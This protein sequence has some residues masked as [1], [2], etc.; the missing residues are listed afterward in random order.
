MA[1][2][3]NEPLI[4]ETLA[5]FV[6]SALVDDGVLP[7]GVAMRVCVD[8]EA[9]TTDT[10]D[11]EVDLP[12]RCDR[13]ARPLGPIAHEQSFAAQPLA[14]PAL[15]DGAEP[16]P[17]NV[18]PGPPSSIEARDTPPVIGA[19]TVP[20]PAEPGAPKPGDAPA[21]AGDAPSIPI[22]GAPSPVESMR[23]AP[24]DVP[25]VSGDAPSI[26]T[27]PAPS[28][29][30]AMAR[31]TGGAPAAGGDA[32]SIPTRG[33][34]SP[35]EA[36]P[37][38]PGNAPAA[39]DDAPRVPVHEP[40]AERVP[41]AV[42]D[43]PRVP[44]GVTAGY[45]APLEKVRGTAPPSEPSVE[46]QTFWFAPREADEIAAQSML[47]TEAVAMALPIDVSLSLNE[48]PIVGGMLPPE[49]GISLRGLTLV[50]TPAGMALR[51]E[52]WLRSE[53]LKV[54]LVFLPQ[55]DEFGDDQ[56]AS[57][58]ATPSGIQPVFWVDVN[59]ALGPLDLQRLGVGFHDEKLWLLMD[60]SLKLG[61]VELI[62]IGLG[63][64]IELG[65]LLSGDPTLPS[66][67]VDG[68]GVEYHGASGTTVGGVL[69]RREED[70]YVGA[71]VVETASLSLSALG[72]FEAPPDGEPS[73]FAYGT[74]GKPLGGP[75]FFYVTRLSLGLGVNTSFT[76][77]AIENVHRF[78]LVRNA[79]SAM[80]PAAP[81]LVD[82]VRT[83]DELRGYQRRTPGTLVLGL[84][85]VGTSFGII[86]TN[87]LLIATIAE[88]IDVDLL[89][90]SVLQLPPNDPVGRIA[91]VRINWRGHWSPSSD[92][93]SIRGLIRPG[94]W[95]F[96]SRFGLS[97]ELAF[98][99]WT[100]GPNAG[101]FVFTVGGYAPWFSKPA[102]YP[103]AARLE[104][105]WSEK[106]GSVSIEVKGEGY[107]AI[108][109]SRLMTGGSLRY[110]LSC[111]DFEAWFKL[112]ADFELQWYPFRY[113]AQLS[114][115]IGASYEINVDLLL[116]T[117]SVTLCV[118]VSADLELWGPD[119][120]GRI[121]F[122]LLD[123]I[124]VSVEFGEDDRASPPLTWQGFK[125]AF[126]TKEPLSLRA[127]G[128]LRDE[129]NE[130]GSRVWVVSPDELSLELESAI[131]AREI[132]TGSSTLDGPSFGV[133]PMKLED[134]SMS[135][136]E[137]AIKDGAGK[138]VSCE[139]EPLRRNMPAA[140]WGTSGT[141]PQQ[142]LIRGLLCG[143]ALA[144]IGTPPASAP[145]LRVPAPEKDINWD[146][147]PK[148]PPAWQQDANGELA[149]GGDFA[150]SW[151][152]A[153]GSGAR[154]SLLREL[155]GLAPGA[156]SPTSEHRVAWIDELQ[157]TPTLK[158]K[159]RRAS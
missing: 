124:D 26:P 63:L 118:E 114:L 89:G 2:P 82:L 14:P 4:H 127:T 20:S 128:G 13:H 44:V 11:V 71:L 1:D 35:S 156:P 91:D 151:K 52:L 112:G 33:A 150:A 140:Q 56:A 141:P 70:V 12:L 18:D 159:T 146:E 130:G 17:S 50:W 37:P 109:P 39:P 79:R 40:A 135:S 122:S 131:P 66:L 138:L 97:G 148:P 5:A 27:R 65:K 134:V 3:S 51:P 121:K 41:E 126:L 125:S 73:L 85:V 28:P 99:A 139:M 75:P 57:A 72:S 54:P 129:T 98:D 107:C 120:G 32:P 21:A 6:E 153:Q 29:V 34:P 49:L 62:A 116:A 58:P 68:L 90:Q 80:L 92:K 55:R 119:L 110:S 24:G 31:A 10:A 87:A 69:V 42:R 36:R 101:D 123:F 86:Q 95:A 15:H 9:S 108:T 48:I 19:R 155:Y 53:P 106:A 74:Y 133:L 16:R 142:R 105:G 30:E 96:H 102:H 152:S 145:P 104:I 81:D 25:A 115:E 45:P 103:S 7:E 88:S 38:A 149:A 154:T 111:G 64:G 93:I 113:R 94:S 78:P 59:K 132:R 8:R 47:A 23:R 84:G 143:V 144:H 117:V 67:H 137:V 157:K 83:A 22:R 60:G 43:T 158:S 61:R 46:S 100:R 136:I 76:L 77:P 147:H